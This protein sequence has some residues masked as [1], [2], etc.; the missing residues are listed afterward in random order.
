L[1]SIVLWCRW[2]VCRYEWTKDAGAVTDEWAGY[3]VLFPLDRKL[4]QRLIVELQQDRFLDKET[5]ELR[6]D[7]TVS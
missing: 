7:Y 5:R 3:K 6:I 1:L 4:A 2:L